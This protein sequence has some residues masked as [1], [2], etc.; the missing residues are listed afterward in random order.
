MSID[1]IIFD[2]VGRGVALSSTLYN[3]SGIDCFARGRRDETGFL[4]KPNP[5]ISCSCYDY[6]TTTTTPNAR[7]VKYF[8]TIVRKFLFVF[9]FSSPKNLCKIKTKVIVENSHFDDCSLYK[10]ET[11]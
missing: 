1:K 8:I 9:L 10:L 2:S 6:T 5:S 3:V 11:D 7:L 4:F